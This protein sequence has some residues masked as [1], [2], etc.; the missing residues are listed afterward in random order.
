M[1]RA[2]RLPSRS[3]RRAAR[4]GG[5]GLPLLGFR[6]A[7]GLAVGGLSD[8]LTLADLRPVGV[9]VLMLVAMEDATV[10]IPRAFAA[11]A[12]ERDGSGDD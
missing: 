9:R 4:A 10:L 8:L 6:L 11:D 7:D 12:S 3:F 2:N 1:F 5:D